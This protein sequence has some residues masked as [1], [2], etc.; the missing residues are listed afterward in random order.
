MPTRTEGARDRA[1]EAEPRAAWIAPPFLVLP[2]LIHA[3]RKHLTLQGFSG[4]DSP[5]RPAPIP[6]RHDRLDSG[7]QTQVGGN[8]RRWPGKHP[9][10]VHRPVYRDNT[11]KMLVRLTAAQG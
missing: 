6:R 3:V 2:N 4:S 5:H 11:G 1:L 8:Y 7:R 10:G 9:Q